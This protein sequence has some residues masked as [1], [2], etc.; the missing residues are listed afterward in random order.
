MTIMTLDMGKYVDAVGNAELSQLWQ[1]FLKYAIQGKETE[2]MQSFS[3]LM[4]K[5][6]ELAE[7]DSQA[8]STRLNR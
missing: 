7:K 4:L 3:Q 8:M 5:T 2:G 6:V 1:D